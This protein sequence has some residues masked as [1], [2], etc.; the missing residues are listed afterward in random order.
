M[1]R[2]ETRGDKGW[3]TKERDGGETRNGEETERKIARKIPRE[4]DRAET[5]GKAQRE[6]DRKEWTKRQLQH[7]RGLDAFILFGVFLSL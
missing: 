1:R 5:E 2:G 4:R 7:H 6:I 3:L